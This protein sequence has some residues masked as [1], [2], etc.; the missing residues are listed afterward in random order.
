[1]R[2]DGLSGW[3]RLIALGMAIAAFPVRAAEVA[4]FSSGEGTNGWR[5]AG[6]SYASPTYPNGVCQI[7]IK[8]E[9][10]NLEA[11]ISV[12]AT[13]ADGAEWSVATFAAASTGAGFTFSQAAGFQSF[14]INMGGET[15]LLSFAVAQF[16]SLGAFP[17]SLLPGGIY[18]QDYN[19]LAGITGTTGGKDWLNGTT[20]PCWQA[21]KG[22]NAVTAVGYNGGKIRTGGLYALASDINDPNRALGGFSTKESTV[23]WGIAFTNDTDA[24]IRLAGVTCSAQQWGFANT[25]EHIFALSFMVTNRMDWIVNFPDGWSRCCDVTARVFATDE[26]H[27]VPVSTP[28]EYAPGVPPSIEPGEVLFLKWEVRPPKSGY[29]AMMAMDDLTVTFTREG[30]PFVIHVVGGQD[31]GY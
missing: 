25:N 8:C 11:L 20:L 1:M 13:A 17:V 19:L 3:G 12:Y 23:S 28:M 30:R 9:G 29:S 15:T 16:P 6:S 22:T 7:G 26:A 24:A 14:R 27:A 4:D 5:I 31:Q 2:G 21:W 18:V 10:A